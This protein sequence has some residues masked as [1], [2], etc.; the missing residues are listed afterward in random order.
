MEP[1]ADSGCL[2]WYSGSGMKKTLIALLFIVVAV[3]F[4][5]VAVAGELYAAS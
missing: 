2:P 4:T 5:Y 3:T 1:Y